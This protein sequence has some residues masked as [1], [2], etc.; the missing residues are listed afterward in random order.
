MEKSIEI[1]QIK[2]DS[3]DLDEISAK[4]D[5]LKF[6]EIDVLNWKEFAYLPET[7]FSIGW[8]EN[9]L[10]IKFRVR[11]EHA[12][13]INEITDSP[14]YQDSCCEFFCS[15]D[16]SGYYN[17]ETNCIGAQLLGWQ[18]KD[19]KLRADDAIISRIKRKSS[20]GNKAPL[21]LEGDV[22]WQLVIIIPADVYFR[23][24]GLKFHR[25]MT[26]RANF[27]KCGDETKIPHFVSWNPIE[28][29]EPNFHKPEYF[30]KAKLV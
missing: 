19:E 28:H 4:L 21:S 23:H 1:P 11:E 15:F 18:A 29:P 25:G 8:D 17:L 12:F 9:H 2:V 27:Y 3:A 5:Q 13:A 10:C 14:V 16:D 20:L 7:E 26:F 24:P 30:G 22:Q 6:H